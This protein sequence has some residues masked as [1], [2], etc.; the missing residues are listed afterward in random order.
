MN[1]LNFILIDIVYNPK[2]NIDWTTILATLMVGIILAILGYF[3]WKRQ[4][5]LQNEIEQKQREEQFQHQIKVE[6]NQ[7][8]LDVYAELN[9]YIRRVE[10]FLE[11]AFNQGLSTKHKNEIENEINEIIMPIAEKFLVYYDESFR[12]TIYDLLEL[13]NNYII[14][15]KFNMDEDKFKDYI[16][17]RMKMFHS[18]RKKATYFF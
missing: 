7:K 1:I 17:I 16:N 8:K 4:F 15:G 6:Y 2:S 3:I 11:I 12:T 5:K 9:P 10:I 13:L 14:E 18:A